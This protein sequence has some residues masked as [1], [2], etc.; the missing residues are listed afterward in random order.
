[1]NKTLQ[2]V[3][4]HNETYFEVELVDITNPVLAEILGEYAAEFP[5]RPSP[6]VLYASVGSNSSS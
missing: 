3:R 1:M 2:T 6:P 4:K 5:V